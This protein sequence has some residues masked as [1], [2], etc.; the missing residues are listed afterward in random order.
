[1]EVFK[2]DLMDGQKIEVV[3]KSSSD[4]IRIVEFVRQY[5]DIADALD[6]ALNQVIELEDKFAEMKVKS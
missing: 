2:I 5:N 1:M 6:T 4:V 3:V